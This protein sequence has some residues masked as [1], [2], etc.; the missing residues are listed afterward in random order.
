MEKEV[1]IVTGGTRGLGAAI[2]KHLKFLGNTV[3]ATYATDSEAAHKFESETGISTMQFDIKNMQ[4]CQAALALIKEELG[5]CSVL[6]NNA[7]VN[8]DATVSSIE[9]HQW[10]QVIRTNLD[11]CFNMT[12]VVWADMKKSEFGRIIHIGSVVSRLG[13]IGISNYVASKAAIEGF[14]R[15]IASEGARYGITSNVI[16]PGYLDT[17][18]G[19]E[20][21][22]KLKERLLGA[23]P[24]KR[25]GA[26]DEIV[27]AVSFLMD[28][29]SSYMTGITLPINGGLSFD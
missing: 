12:K 16:A 24:M 2:S 1:V 3:I 10:D 15:S 25:F 19:R 28:R 8:V 5:P 26:T 18:M 29:C 14:S 17:G 7:G 6:I 11:G 20:I 23:I 21:P 13:G 27:H 22:A 4:A 9:S